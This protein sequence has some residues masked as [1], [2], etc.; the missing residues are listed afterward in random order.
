[1]STNNP[2]LTLHDFRL[3]SFNDMG[4]NDKIAYLEE[5][6]GLPA[7]E[8][9]ATLV[10]DGTADSP[11][12]VALPT[13]GIPVLNVTEAPYSAVGDG[14]T[15]DSVA[16]RAAITAAGTAGG[17]IIYF[18]VGTYLVSKDPTGAW[19]LDITCANTTL[20]GVKGA[21]VI[22][23]AASALASSVAVLR[24][25]EKDNVTLTGLVIDG[26]WG[27]PL[28]YVDYPSDGLVLP[29]ATI[30]VESTSPDGTT[31]PSSG[32]FTVETT[33]GLETITYTG[34]TATT[35]TGCTGGTGTLIG[36][37][38]NANGPQ[39][40]GKPVGLS[41]SQTGLNH[42]TQ[43]DPK[44]YG[45]FIRGAENIAID[46]CIFR[47]I[48]GDAIWCGQGATNFFTK[49]TRNVSITRTK[50]RVCARDGITFGQKCENIRIH[51]C[52]V[53]NTYAECIDTEP[54]G[55]GTAV[56]NVSIDSNRLE[57]WWGRT[58]P[59]RD[60][61]L[62]LSITSSYSLASGPAS[63]ARNYR[64]TNNHITGGV[65]I[66]N[67]TDIVVERNKITCDWSGKGYSPVVVL[68][69][70]NDITVAGNR[71]YSMVTGWAGAVSVVY[72]ASGSSVPAPRNVHVHGNFIHARNGLSGIHVD[73]QGGPERGGVEVTGTTGTATGVSGVTVTDSGAAWAASQWVS[74]NVKMGSAFGTITAST[75]TTFTVDDWTTAEGEAVVQPV[76]GAYT[77]FTGGGTLDIMDNTID[78]TNDGNGQGAFGIRVDANRAAGRIRIHRNTT[79]NATTAAIKVDTRFRNL[80]LADIRFNHARTNE[81]TNTAYHVTFDT[82]SNI[83]KLIFADNTQENSIGAVSGLTTG[84]WLESDGVCQRWS[85]YDT[86][87]A[88][89]TA[90][91]GSTY[92]RIN[93][94]AGTVFYVKETGAGNTGWVAK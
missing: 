59:A 19:C 48:Y 1:M 84:T 34:K 64:V 26:N 81:V 32:T 28:T 61:N 49:W 25:N 12:G 37:Q 78:C 30:Q 87:E 55:T 52:E 7:V 62:A 79:T 73:G 94:G 83:N 16:I 92:F 10:G 9:D 45:V 85:G 77:I 88:V 72:F 70:C 35:F 39:A 36:L 57:T 89:V 82:P 14:V 65:Y 11:L 58:D 42:A 40:R 18:P 93:G 69:A 3:G 29:Q 60:A 67:S 44:N 54:V 21:S 43:A 20:M 91:V 38:F 47:Q 90:P 4:I 63:A 56:R 75:A 80:R 76:V 22:K 71:I 6:V 17:A 13:T 74:F 5:Q 41:N 31:F 53:S 27:N 66:T 86:P 51:H 68:G 33:A 46:N 50:I 24:I 15:D 23:A 8:H 2:S